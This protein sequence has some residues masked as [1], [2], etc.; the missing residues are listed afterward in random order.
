MKKMGAK[1]VDSV[2]K[3]YLLI[4]IK[5]IFQFEKLEQTACRSILLMGKL[6][7]L[8]ST[9]KTWSKKKPNEK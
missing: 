6:Q 9:W 5:F 8:D 3:I 7:D 1:P 2:A 4:K